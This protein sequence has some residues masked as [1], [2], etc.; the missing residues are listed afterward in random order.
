MSEFSL[1]EERRAPVAPADIPI[2]RVRWADTELVFK[3]YGSGEPVVLL[4]GI[5]GCIDTWEPVI[6]LLGQN[7]QVIAA[8]LPGH[9]QTLKPRGDYSVGAFATAVRDLLEALDL[10]SATIIGH[11]LGGGVG[12]QFAYQYPDRC[13]RLVLVGSGG[14]GPDVTPMLR[15]A[16]LPGSDGFIRLATSK[17]MEKLGR[18]LLGKARNRGFTLS[19]RMR[20]SLRH[21]LSLRDRGARRAFIAT[22]RST[23][24]LRG[25]RMSAL[26][27]LHVTSDLPLL[28][29]WGAKDDFIPVEHAKAAHRVAPHSRLEIFEDSG[30]FPQEEEPERFARVVGDFLA[31]TQPGNVSMAQ[32]KKKA[33]K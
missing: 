15:A 3:R 33:L 21:F 11:S 9:G 5:A 26:P 31:T 10:P 30:H 22:A 16:T 17:L 20:A 12:L 25:Q 1:A 13:D 14:L 32:F 24:D 18:A 6:P 23:I 8:D 2:E 27:R 7:Y 28:L 19:I 29:V 4:H